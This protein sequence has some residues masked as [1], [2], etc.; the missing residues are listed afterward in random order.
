MTN[1]GDIAFAFCSELMDVYCWANNVPSTGS[2]A[3]QESYIEYATLH[4]QEES[5]EKYK[6]AEPW[7]RFK[8]IVKAM[9]LHTLTYIVD[10]NIYKSYQ[11]EENSSITVEPNP[12]KEGYTFSGWSDVP[13]TMPAHDVIVTGSFVINKY[14]VTYIID[15]EVFATDYIEYGATIVPPSVGEKE[16]FT[17]SGWNDIP[18]TMPAYDITIY[19]SFTSGIAEILMGAQ[20]NARIY[21]PNGKRIDRLQKGLNIV[22]L[23]DGTA[24]KIVVK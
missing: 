2:N 12:Q 9:P 3:F 10:G 23:D 6:H 19:G 11:V 7:K 16:G 20:R 13:E 24:K 22:I 14:K 5:I 8:N 17:F 1:I 18:E 21:L 4:V 15:G